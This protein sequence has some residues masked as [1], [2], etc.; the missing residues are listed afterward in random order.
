MSVRTTCADHRQ[1]WQLCSGEKGNT[2]GRGAPPAQTSQ[3]SSRKFSS[4]DSSARTDNARL[5][6]RGSRPTLS[7]CP[8][9]N[10]RALLSSASS[11]ARQTVSCRHA[12]TVRDLEHANGS[13][14]RSLILCESLLEPPK[15]RY[16]T[17]LTYPIRCP[18]IKL[19]IPSCG[20]STCRTSSSTNSERACVTAPTHCGC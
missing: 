11:P 16:R 18:R 19:T 8:R 4:A 7:R 20:T 3:Q 15:V 14:D 1:A 12:G 6:I 2:A 5:Q 9:S 10:S 17:L 13:A